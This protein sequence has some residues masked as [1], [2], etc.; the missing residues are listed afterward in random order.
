MTKPKNQKSV[1]VTSLKSLAGAA[2]EFDLPVSIPRRDGGVE[3]IILRTKSLRKSEWAAMRDESLKAQRDTNKPKGGAEFS[4]AEFV[5]SGSKE[6][7]ELVCKAGIGWDLDDDFTP[8]N[9]M[10]LEDLIPNSIGTTLNAI[11]L[12]LFQGRLGN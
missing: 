7:A 2:V 6:A 4:F 9:L 8:E 3:S 12:A 11:D 10:E 1:P 5:A